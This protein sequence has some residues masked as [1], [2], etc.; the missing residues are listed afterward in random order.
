MSANPSRT[1]LKLFLVLLV[2]AG[3]A[4]AAFFASRPIA[5]VET[6]RKGNVADVVGAT[7]VVEPGVVSPIMSEVEGRLIE[8]KLA[9]G[10]EF[11][12]GDVI[13][14]IDPADVD[15]EIEHAQSEYDAADKSIK[16]AQEIAQLRVASAKEDLK[17]AER[18]FEKKDL[19]ENDILRKRREE[20][21]AEQSRLN[22]E[23]EN[24][25][26][27]AA[28]KNTLKVALRKKDKMT[29]KAPFDGVVTEVFVNPQDLV[30]GKQSL[31]NLIALTRLV[32]A[33]IPEE[34][35]AAV[36][37]GQRVVVSLLGYREKT[38]EA[39]IR[40]KLPTSEPG[41]QRYSAFLDIEIEPAKLVPGLTGDAAIYV[42]EH[43][44][45]VLV[46]RRALSDDYVFV[47]EGSVVRQQRVEL[48]FKDL[49]VAEVKTGLKPGD[50]VIVE[51]LD[52]F[53]PGQR[54][55]VAE[56]K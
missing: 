30:S 41:T 47:V 40:A 42:D 37:V 18:L 16:I 21:V 13:A 20:E 9:V 52:L 14:R 36:Q 45:V 4:A 54:V 34:H 7:V 29:I 6:I 25:R 19:A 31:A 56:V 22:D 49:N 3:G 43:R 12:A 35:F 10:T 33:K 28:L 53:R 51:E 44:D 48:G 17:E 50:R 27:L 11:K 55:R 32:R 2:L 8:S 5:R 26:R 39:K 24:V 1:G 15:L 38:F 23:A 46:P